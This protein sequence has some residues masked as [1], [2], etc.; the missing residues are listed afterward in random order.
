MKGLAG[1]LLVVAT[2][3]SAADAAGT[4]AAP[5]PGVNAAAAAPAAAVAAPPAPLPAI[6]LAG[7]LPPAWRG[8]PADEASGTQ[9]ASM[10]YP[11]PN[12]AGLL[13]A[14]LTHAVIVSGT[15]ESARKARQDEADK[16]LLPHQRS[17]DRL[18]AERVAQSAAAL[19]SARPA[20]Q[21]AAGRVLEVRPSF[22]LA[23]DQ[24]VLVLDSA[25]KIAAAGSTAA[26]Q[27]EGIVRVVSTPR[28][29]LEPQAAWTAEDGRL[30]EQEAVAML[31]HSLELALSVANRPADP[32]SARTQRYAHGAAE[33]MERG[34][35][36]ASGCGRV[37][38]RN[39]RDWLMSVPV[40]P[41]PPAAAMPGASTPGA[42]APEAAAPSAC[43][44]AYTL[45]APAR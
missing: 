8:I 2:R 17:I 31:A 28:L 14:I 27:F 33:K 42:T 43:A 1:L 41:T 25:V 12:A 44:D 30:L 9:G 37:V 6:V 38:L 26:P 29:D 23:P 15:R 10:M 16:V 40:V 34:E 32:A 18:T 11:A 13:A 22:A 24:R 21:A 39:L 19:L 4:V 45:A 20:A 36:L 35:L 7:G 3:A 5:A